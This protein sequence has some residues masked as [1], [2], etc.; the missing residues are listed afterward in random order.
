M[1]LAVT[2]CL[3]RM[4]GNISKE[5]ISSENNLELAIEA[6]NSPNIGDDLGEELNLGKKNIEVIS[7]SKIKS[8]L[9]KNPVDVLIDFTRP[10]ATVEFAKACS[11]TKTNLVI[12]T[13]GFEPSQK[14]EIINYINNGQIAAVISPNY[15]IGVNVFW[16]AV[17]VVADAL[18]YDA[19]IVEAHHNG[20]KD[21][22]SGTAQKT[23]EIIKNK[24]EGS[25]F[26][27][28]RH[29]IEPREKNEIGIHAIRA[30]DIIGDHTTYFSG[31]NSGERIEITHRAQSRQPFVNGA[32]RAAEYVNKKDS[33]IYDMSDVLGLSET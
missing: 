1:D 8:N 17:E 24:R 13:T 15:A 2:G 32:I 33:G 11:E 28:G 7:S 22:P 9:E 16:K 10:E 31:D 21:A 5:I 20:K 4:G 26:K 30:G 25:K 3:G 23:A 27:Y 29:G 6:P 12:G 14:Q 18:D 19:E